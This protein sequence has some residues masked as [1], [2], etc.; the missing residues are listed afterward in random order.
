MSL[1]SYGIVDLSDLYKLDIDSVGKKAHEAGMLWKLGIPLPS[2][3]VITTEFFKE[4]LHLTKID[5]EI[6]KMQNLVHPALS[7]SR[8]KLFHP[9]RKQILQ[10]HLPQA[11]ATQLHSFYRKFSTTFKEKPLNVYSSSFDNRS[12]IFPM[13]KGDA[14]L[15]L[16]IKTIWSSSFDNP[17]GI[18]VQEHLSAEIKGKTITNN[19]TIDKKLSKDQMEKLIAYCKIIQKCFYFPYEIEYAVSKNKLF[20][21][22][23]QPFT[24][25]AIK[26]T[27]QKQTDKQ[28]ARNLLIKGVPINPGIATGQVKIFHNIHDNINVKKSDIVVLKNINHFMLKIIKNAKAVIIETFLP[29]TLSKTMYK[30]TIHAPTIVNAKNLIKTIKNG[31]VV[32]VNGTTGEIFSGGLI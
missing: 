11:L 3:F 7:D 21:L 27:A 1:N 19:P 16:K 15:V 30:K 22:K 24:G 25:D 31:K 32:T 5:K 9:I 18:V 26:I 10:K 20:I 13:I 4:F 14:N 28:H 8:E 23:I 29:N 2:G 6:K 12:I 17:V